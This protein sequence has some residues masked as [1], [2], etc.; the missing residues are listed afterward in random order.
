MMLQADEERGDQ[1]ATRTY[2]LDTEYSKDAQSI[3]ERA[4]QINKVETEI[5]FTFFND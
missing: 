5:Y 3:F 4:Q 2:E 1:G